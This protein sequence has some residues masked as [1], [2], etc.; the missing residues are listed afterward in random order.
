MIAAK[1]PVLC[2]V[3]GREDQ[4]YIE[5]GQV[6]SIVEKKFVRRPLEDQQPFLAREKFLA[7]ML[8]DPIDQ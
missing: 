2:E 3:M 4:N 1:G 6:K 7:E 5:V 8:I